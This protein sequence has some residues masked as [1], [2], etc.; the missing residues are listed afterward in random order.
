MKKLL[1]VL[2]LLGGCEQRAA[3]R[4]P[5][6]VIDAGEASAPDAVALPDPPDG[7]PAPL[8]ASEAGGPDAALLA[9]DAGALACT[10][11]AADC[12]E[13][14]CCAGLF[15]ETNAYL[16]THN[17]CVPTLADGESCLADGQCSSGRC[18]EGVCAAAECGVVG[19]QCFGVEF[20]CCPGLACDV[21]ADSYGPG[22]CAPVAALG[23]PCAGDAQCA[24]GRCAAGRC[25]E[26]APVGA[27]TFQRVFDEVLVPNGCTNGYCHGQSAGGLVLRDVD[28]AFRALVGPLATCDG[29]ARVVPGAPEQSALWR[30][31]APGVM[32]CGSKM[33]PAVGSVSPVAAEL[34]RQWI[35]EG[36]AR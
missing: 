15:C 8:D 4:I 1:I 10:V 24:S 34:V 35:A 7:G 18:S 32:A 14:T 3:I 6:I 26:P 12:S 33:P 2:L 13:T 30:K 11:A 19:Q 22:A 29:S 31:I 20:P 27:A 16:M 28:G 25:A 9:E 17:T 21:P 5:T 36:A 23:E